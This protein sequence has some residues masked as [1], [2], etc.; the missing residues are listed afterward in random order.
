[1]KC[2]T[3]KDLMVLYF[4]NCCS[5]ESRREVEEHIKEC[6][7]C[8]TA[9]E[10]MKKEVPLIEK[11]TPSVPAKFRRI[12]ERKASV[13]QSILLFLSFAL[14]VVGTTLEASTPDGVM[15][16]TWAFVLIVPSVG[17]MLSLANWYF[18]R[19]YKNKKSFSVCSAIAT[20]LIASCGY[21]WA[22]VHY[23]FNVRILSF[24]IGATLTFLLSALSGFLSLKYASLIGKD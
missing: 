21:I 6:A 10:E 24:I 14:T 3:V 5:D 22:F 20:F 13:L 17:F 8:R 9:F 19:I 15:N 23:G 1:M 16:G 2:E 4:D 12:N 11:K 7:E 18:V